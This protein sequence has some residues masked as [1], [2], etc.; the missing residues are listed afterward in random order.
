[1]ATPKRKP[2]EIRINGKRIICDQTKLPRQNGVVVWKPRTYIKD[3][4]PELLKEFDQGT[5]AFNK[6]F[7]NTVIDKTK[8]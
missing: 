1:M 5:Q 2:F 7:K 6:K 4:H 8:K 3:H